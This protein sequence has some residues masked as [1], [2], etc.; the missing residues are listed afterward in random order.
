VTSTI[1]TPARNRL[2]GGVRNSHHL[3]GRALDVVRRAGVRH[4][5]IEAAL[6]SEG[7]NVVESLD[8]GDHSHFAFRLAPTQVSPIGQTAQPKTQTPWRG[9]TIVK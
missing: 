3:H 2:V 5:E 1:R 6:R 8:E 4:S 7:L 9:M